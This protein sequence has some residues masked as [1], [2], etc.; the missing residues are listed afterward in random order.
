[1]TQTTWAP[2]RVMKLPVRTRTARPVPSDGSLPSHRWWRIGWQ[3]DG[4]GASVIGLVG[5]RSSVVW[6]GSVAVVPCALT[7][8]ESGVCPC[9]LHA[10]A[11]ATEAARALGS[12][13][14]GGCVRRLETA[15]AA[16]GADI[17]V[18]AIEGPLRVMAWCG[19]LQNGFTVERCERNPRWV[20]RDAGLAVVL[21]TRHLLRSPGR[22]RFD[23]VPF[24]RFLGRMVGELER[25]GVE[26]RT[27][28]VQPEQPHPVGLPACDLAAL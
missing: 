20:V 4:D 28:E 22:L 3:E 16:D 9:G 5:C 8:G 10:A 11:D 23:A 26:V 12:L 19:G 7:G 14:V 13:V 18:A 21:C 6:R 17:V 15:I 1:M 27:G 24:N 25:Y 2:S